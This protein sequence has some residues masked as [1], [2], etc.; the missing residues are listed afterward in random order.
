MAIRN[1]LTWTWMKNRIW[2][3]YNADFDIYYVKDGRNIQTSYGYGGWWPAFKVDDDPRLTKVLGTKEGVASYGDIS[4]TTNISNPAVFGNE[5]YNY[6]LIEWFITNNNPTE[7]H[8]VSLATHCD[9]MIANNDRATIYWYQNDAVNRRGL[10][11]YDSSTSYRLTLMVKD[12]YQVTNVDHFWYGPWGRYQL[13]YW[14][15]RTEAGKL[16]GYDSA[17]SFGWSNRVVRENSTIRLAVLLGV[18]ENLVSPPTVEV[19]SQ[20]QENYLPNYDFTVTGVFK[21]INKDDQVQVRYKYMNDEEK[22]AT[23]FVDLSSPDGNPVQSTF[24]I[25]IRT[26]AN[27]S[28]NEL[29]IYAVNKFGLKSNEFKYNVLVNEA[30]VLT[31]I[32]QIQPKYYTGGQVEVVGRLWDDTTANIY[33]QFDRD[34]D[35]EAD[36]QVIECNK[37]EKPFRKVFA[38]REGKIDYGQHTLYI[39][40]ED[41]FHVKSRVYPFPFEYKELHAPQVKIYNENFTNVYYDQYLIVRGAVKDQD[42]GDTIT[43]SMKTPETLP[44]DP[45]IQVEQITANG[46][47]QNFTVYYHLD[48]SLPA[49]NN[50]IIFQAKDQLEAISPDALFFFN[51]SKYNV[52]ANPSPTPAETPSDGY[53][54]G[55]E[56]ESGYYTAESST[57]TYTETPTRDSN[58]DTST[59]Y[60]LTDTKIIIVKKGIPEPTTPDPTLVG[61]YAV[62]KKVTKEKQ[63]SNKIIWI[64]AGVAAGVALAVAAIIIAV[65]ASKKAK[66]F[67]FD[68]ED[69]EN[70]G[71]EMNDAAMENDNPIYDDGMEDDPF[72]NEFDEPEAQDAGMFPN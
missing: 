2:D 56:I 4:V 27:V 16:E 42:V 59:G 39:W 46:D 36:K 22:N 62:G 40:A 65:E 14:E 12:A 3:D 60:T 6:L 13:H 38:L 48:V 61:A 35:F 10:T 43:L 32:N 64:A 45:F 55:S 41:E 15:D 68:D 21:T 30:P 37:E 53:V 66:E 29:Q 23:E 44:T 50:S 5:K 58:G 51:V 63:S 33:Y 70:W 49:G 71:D 11:M 67:N 28:L 20:F 1:G 54:P 34:F 31:I 25:P 47:W 17:F 18:G 69:V 52:V 7:P 72:A 8:R 9:V 26:P 24:S 19:T 57:S